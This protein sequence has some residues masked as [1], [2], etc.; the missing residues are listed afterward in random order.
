MAS[1]IIAVARGQSA[2]QLGLTGV[3]VEEAASVEA[4]EQRLDELLVSDAEML[5][6]EEALRD[7]FSEWFRLR[8]AR[9]G[10]LPLVIF[11]PAFASEDAGTDAYI[12]AIL[13]PAV[14]FEIR[15]D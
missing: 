11:A 7:E 1:K 12:N 10:G 13:K 6:V 4:A 8:L 2:L 15:L 5:I 14:G 3:R 9:H